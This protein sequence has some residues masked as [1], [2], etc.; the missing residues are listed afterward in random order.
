MYTAATLSVVL[1]VLLSSRANALSA[2]RSFV[3]NIVAG[4][5]AYL[6]LEAPREGQASF[7]HVNEIV[8]SLT[9]L[10]W[11]VDLYQP[12]YHSVWER[13][14]VFGRICTYLALQVCLAMRL[15]RY[16]LLYVRA[17]FMA[18]PVAAVCAVWKKPVVHE[19]NGPYGDIFVT[20]PWLQRFRTLLEKCQRW[21]YRTARGLI[22]V[23]SKLQRWLGEEAPG[24]RAEII[25]NGANVDLFSPNR[26]TELSL[27]GKFV[28]FFGGL[29]KW[30]GVEWMLS[31]VIEPTWPKDV[32]LV[33]VGDGPERE[34]V[35]RAR[36]RNECVIW[37]GRLPYGEV[38][39]VVAKALA[40][41]VCITDP[42]GWSSTGVA[43]IKLYETLACGVPVIVSDLPGQAEFVRDHRVGYVVQIGDHAG[44]ASAVSKLNQDPEGA[45]EMGR[46]G[47]DLV[48]ES[49]SWLARAKQT[50]HFLDEILAQAVKI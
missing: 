39:G 45:A 44:L 42:S 22:P 18:V 2:D 24:V 27:P 8:N 16:D 9:R 7:A 31:S 30:H 37:L 32:K 11:R 21:Q 48:C 6:T 50:S 35:L 47:R 19:V 13:P 25:P 15:G 10:G 41:I 33:L 34:S 23:T 5:L 46:R 1:V 28:V 4:T 3:E 40:G 12:H 14:G 29:S 36:E 49:H 20:Y 43:P 38:G 17:H 26:Q